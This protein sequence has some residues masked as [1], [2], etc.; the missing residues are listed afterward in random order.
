MRLQGALITLFMFTSIPAFSIKKPVFPGLGEECES[1]VPQTDNPEVEVLLGKF[2][3]DLKLLVDDSDFDYCEFE[4][5]SE[6]LQ[7]RFAHILLLAKH[8]YISS[9]LHLKQRFAKCIFKVM[10]NSIPD[11]K[12]AEENDF[13]AFRFLRRM[14]VL[15]IR[16]LALF[17][18]R[19]EPDLLVEKYAQKVRN[20]KYSMEFWGERFNTL[21]HIPIDLRT[22]FDDHFRKTKRAVH[23]LEKKIPKNKTER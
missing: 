9:A 17:K 6:S 8:N 1:P 14:I 18:S 5:Q 2:I 19:N 21:T 12:E 3:G 7:G 13:Q 16:T 23:K 20:L 11:L 10:S 22:K 4:K 15:H